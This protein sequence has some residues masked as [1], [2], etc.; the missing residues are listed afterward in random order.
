VEGAAV[1]LQL[2]DGRRLRA[3][4]LD[5]LGSAARPMSDAQLEAKVRSLAAH[6]APGCDA[7]HLI[8]QVWAIEALDDAG[9][10]ARLAT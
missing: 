2:T 4:V 10:I 5:A 6:G 3:E 1:E 7:G 8:E 9:A